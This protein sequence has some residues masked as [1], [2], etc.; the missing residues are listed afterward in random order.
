MD[1]GM[2]RLAMVGVA[3]LGIWE[4]LLTIIFRLFTSRP[5]NW[6]TAANHLDS[7]WCYVVAGGV[8]AVAVVLLSALDTARKKVLAKA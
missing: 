8:I 2:Y 1:E 7:P 6:L 4:G 5:P 3:F